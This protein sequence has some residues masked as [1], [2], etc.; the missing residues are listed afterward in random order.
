MRIYAVVVPQSVKL[1]R[2]EKKNKQNLA[3]DAFLHMHSK[4]QRDIAW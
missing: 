3:R 2:V 4:E 1:K